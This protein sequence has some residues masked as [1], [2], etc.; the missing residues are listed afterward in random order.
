[1]NKD[2]GREIKDLDYKDAQ[3]HE[4]EQLDPDQETTKVSPGNSRFVDCASQTDY[5]GD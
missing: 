5:E 3:N 4:Q 2:K 1:M